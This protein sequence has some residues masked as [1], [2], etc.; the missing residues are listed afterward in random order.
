MEQRLNDTTA[1]PKT[2]NSSYSTWF[3]LLVLGG[4]VFVMIAS[5][6]GGIPAFSESFPGRKIMIASF[7]RLRYSLGDRVFPQVLIGQEGWMEYTADGNLD[8]YQNAYLDLTNLESIRKKLIALDEELAQRNI[9]LIVVVVPNKATIYPDKLPANLDK[10][11][12]TSRLDVFLDM[13][14]QS[15]PNLVLDVR[16]ALKQARE[17]HQV[18][19]RTDT[20]WNSLGAYTAYL[21]IMTAVS[22]A[23]P[24]L[25]PYMLNK[26]RIKET[27]PQTM[28]L[29]LINGMSFIREAPVFVEPK[30]DGVAHFQRFPPLSSFSMS[31]GM[32]DQEQTL[33]MY[34]DSF[35]V[36][37]RPFLM[38]H[39]KQ[40]M[41][42]LNSADP[43]ISSLSWIDIVQPN[44][45]IIEIAE[46]SLPYLN[47]LLS[48]P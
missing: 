26:F 40:A 29:A 19:Y 38:N 4:F 44:I 41:Y 11:Q 13:M 21:E 42:I 15:D 5:L 20:H 23:Y 22:Q 35:G 33:L 10:L 6:R 36:A 18:Y 9:T 17:S 37:L 2:C 47:T 43:N 25:Q 39:F 12:K 48:N 28:D 3:I 1:T 16:Q 24:E 8:D 14:E 34:H 30:F 7:N 31:W 27:N 45:V 32:G 46:R